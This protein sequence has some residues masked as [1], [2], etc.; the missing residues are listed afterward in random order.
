MITV[1]GS[2]EEAAKMSARL[3]LGWVDGCYGSQLS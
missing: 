2:R 3:L 1:E